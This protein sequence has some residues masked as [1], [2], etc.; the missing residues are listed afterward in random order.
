MLEHINWECLDFRSWMWYR[1]CALRLFSSLGVGNV[2]FF[3]LW[4]AHPGQWLTWEPASAVHAAHGE[5]K[6]IC[7]WIR[8]TLWQQGSFFFLYQNLNGIVITMVDYCFESVW[9]SA[10]HTK[11]VEVKDDRNYKSIQTW[12]VIIVPFI[13]AHQDHTSL[14]VS[15][16]YQQ[17]LPFGATFPIASEVVS[18]I[19]PPNGCEQSFLT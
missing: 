16:G 5:I 18:P 19:P 13:Q 3:W 7:S 9:K 14:L 4:N 12:W 6:L 11:K 15:A 1:G 8:P 2:S 10:Y 17:R